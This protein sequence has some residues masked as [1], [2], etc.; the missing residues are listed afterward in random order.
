MTKNHFC[1]IWKSNVIIL[2]KALKELKLNFQIVDNVIFDKHVKS[3]IKHEYK[4]KKVQSQVTKKIVYGLETFNIDRAIPYANGIWKLSEIS[5]KYNRDITDR[6][7]EKCRK[8]CIV[9]EGTDSINDFLDHVLQ[10]KGEPKKVNKK[11][12]NIIY[13]F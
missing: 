10:L 9:L 6:E 7:L 1:L 12:V 8:H 2:N 11:I 4:P 13:I 3:C 5:G